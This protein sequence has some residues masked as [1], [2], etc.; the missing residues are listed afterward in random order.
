MAYE[1]INNKISKIKRYDK[2]LRNEQTLIIMT[3][4]NAHSKHTRD[5][6]D[7]NRSKRRKVIKV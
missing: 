5:V 6:S 1:S 2:A 3:Y 4:T 7:G